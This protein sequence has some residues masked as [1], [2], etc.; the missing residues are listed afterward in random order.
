MPKKSQPEFKIH[1]DPSCL[2]NPTDSEMTP[3]RIASDQTIIHHDI[4]KD[5]KDIKQSEETGDMDIVD[6]EGSREQR[7]SEEAR[8]RQIDRIEAQIQA[9]ARAVVASIEQDNYHGDDS[10]MSSQTD[11]S[12]DQEHS[13]ISY[14]DGTEL[15]YGHGT[16]LTYDG[17]EVI[18][19][20]GDEH[21]EQEGEGDGDSS[22]HHEGDVDDDVF[23]NSD[24]SKRSSLNSCVDISSADEM[25]GKE[26]TSPM[27]GEEAASK[28]VS[29]LPSTSSY[30]PPESTP[31]TLSR[32]LTRPPFRTPS[33]VRAMQ[34]SSPTPSL[35]SSP[36][37]SKRHVPTISRLGTPSSKRTPT[38][39][40]S[41]VE[42]PLVLLHVTVLPL[43]WNYSHAMS[44][45]NLP[46]EL[47]QI[48]DSWRLLQ[49]QLCEAIVERGILLAHPQDDYEV[50]EE[51]LLEALEL[52]VRPRANILRCGHYMGSETPSSDD[53]CQDQFFQGDERKWCEVC[54]KEVKF[55]PS[56]EGSM[57]KRFR[58]KIYASNGLMRAGAWS[59]CWREMEKVD[60]ELS[61]F[62]EDGLA[63]PLEQFASKIPTVTSAT[64]EPDDGFLDEEEPLPRSHEAAVLGEIE[65]MKAE[66]EEKRAAE[67]ELL[68]Q[69]IANEERMK[70]IYGDIAF[71]VEEPQVRRQQKTALVNSDSF[72]E[73]LFAALKVAMRDTK[74]VAI[75][76]LTILVLAL[77]LRSKTV[78]IAN[79]P[80]QNEVDRTSN[81]DVLINS[82]PNRASDLISTSSLSAVTSVAVDTTAEVSGVGHKEAHLVQLAGTAVNLEIAPKGLAAS[83]PSSSKATP[84]IAPPNEQFEIKGAEIID[85]PATDFVSNI[86]EPKDIPAYSNEEFAPMEIATEESTVPGPAQADHNDPDLKEVVPV[87]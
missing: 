33:S 87:V 65:Q 4:K 36:R 55:E 6:N 21:A 13:H 34:M 58:V 2:T 42:D 59:A 66:E 62:V 53:E 7:H 23:T 29:R 44:A 38:R 63:T 35:F 68:R 82:M 41:R 30:A 12:Y 49:G 46:S 5:S 52:H 43:S 20:T 85:L 73:L 69:K 71:G 11:A 75:V 40:K 45:D 76:I 14:E 64:Y 60:V 8:E 72:P 54:G 86:P 15:T 57:G 74:N 3:G 51:R 31:I 70:E 77:A 19:E 10:V 28:P 50:L 56:M 24:H 83:K 79:P 22:S 25:Q 78:V 32:V 27:V 81:S 9:A 48:R 18:H 47:Q 16:E 80:K 67:V 37:S 1:V 61:P 39:F 84:K 26:L 17:T